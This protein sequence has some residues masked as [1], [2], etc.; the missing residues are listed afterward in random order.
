MRK[1]KVG[2]KISPKGEFSY[3]GLDDINNHIEQGKKIISIQEG[4]ALMRKIED[5]DGNKKLKLTGF[6]LTVLVD[7]EEVDD[8]EKA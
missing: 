6:S 7:E 4:D 1:I 3:F 5:Q 2:L 8:E